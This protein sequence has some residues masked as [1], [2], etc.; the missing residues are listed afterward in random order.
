MALTLNEISRDGHQFSWVVS[1]F[2]FGQLTSEYPAIYLMSRL[3]ITIFVGTS[4]VLWGGCEMALG[5]A[6]NFQ[7]LAAARFFLGFAEGIVS[8]SFIII[9]SIFYK[10]KEHPI[11][12]AT[13]ISM[14]GVSQIAGALMMYGIGGSNMKLENWR[15]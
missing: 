12:V 7:G 1:L 15:A 8:P 14:S 6:Q 9:T 3:P 2:Y 10:R 4:I 11:R 5:A 13:W